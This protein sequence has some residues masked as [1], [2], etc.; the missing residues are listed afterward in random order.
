MLLQFLLFIHNHK[1]DK[2]LVYF[3]AM[4]LY[5]AIALYMAMD[6]VMAMAR[7]GEYRK[8]SAFRLGS[9]LGLCFWELPRPHAGNFLYSPPLVKVHTLYST[10]QY[11]TVSRDDDQRNVYLSTWWLQRC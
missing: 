6:M 9:S 11:N 3:L 4:A 2:I 10:T 1:S 7:V 5:M 8:I